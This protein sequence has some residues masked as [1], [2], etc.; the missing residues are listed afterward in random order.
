MPICVLYMLPAPFASHLTRI[1]LG[2]RDW[3]EGGEKR[4]AYLPYSATVCPPML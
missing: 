2:V 3:V 1:Q 4:E